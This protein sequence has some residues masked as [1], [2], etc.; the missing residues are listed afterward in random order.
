MSTEIEIFI[1]KLYRYDRKNEHCSIGFPI[2]RGLVSD[3]SCFSVWDPVKEIYLPVQVKATSRYPDGSIRFVFIRFIA[4]IPA[5]KKSTFICKIQGS[6]ENAESKEVTSYSPVKITK[7]SAGYELSTKDDVTDRE[8][9]LGLSDNSDKLLDHVT[10]G[11]IAYEGGMFEGPVLR[12]AKTRGEYLIRSGSWEIVE[13]GPL[14]VILRNKGVHVNKDSDLRYSFEAGLTFWAGKSYAEVS[15]RIINDTEDPLE[16]ESLVYRIKRDGEPGDGQVFHVSNSD[17]ADKLAEK[18]DLGRVRAITA[19]SNYKTDYYIGGDGAASRRLIDAEWLMKEANEH[20]AETFYGTFFADVTGEDTGICATIFQA[21]QN[22]PKAVEADG[23]GIALFLVPEGANSIVLQS[24]MSREQRFLIHFHEAKE[25][26][27]SLN[28]RSI[29][30]QMPYRP[31]VLPK[32]HQR[33]GVWPDVFSKKADYKVEQN[34]I[35]RADGHCRAYGM[36]NFGDCYDANY[37]AQGRGC[38]KLVWSN[39]EYDY[40]HACAIMF[41]RTGIRRF[42]DYNIAAAR[43]WM[44]VD[45]CHFHR[46]PIYV[47]GQWEHT[48]GHVIDGKMVCSHEW[49][50]GLLDYYHLTGDE[51]G[52]E[53][54]LG[55]GDNVN[56]LLDTPMYAKAGEISA[57]ETGWAL[58]TL[59]ALYIETGDKKWLKKCDKILGDFKTWEEQYGHWLSPYTDNTIIRVGFMISVAIGSLMRY[60]REFPDQ[61]QRNL[62][63]RAVDDLIENCYVE[64]W[65]IFYYK[66]LPSLNRLGNNTLLLEA[67]TIAYDLTKDQKYLEYGM[68]TFRKAVSDSPNYSGSKRKEED[69]VLVGT[70]STKNFAQSMIPIA[71]FHRAMVEAGLEL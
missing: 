57:R 33:A 50:E 69:A 21:Q 39:N 61:E 49:V 16:V 9:K 66:E 59:T 14:C 18:E 60:Y 42:L 67:M 17:E 44:D 4:D 30:Y 35:A 1:D 55:I 23:S 71:G 52:L 29:V 31:Y 70:T 20:F 54:A 48:V 36:L 25:S 45:V 47:G 8:F 6:D 62:I 51:R 12:T 37:T 10:F 28:D 64:E 34:L 5:N 43:H 27:S 15:Y 7:T 40:P 58:R 24:G 41:A 11:N 63:I 26:I 13:E 65:G 2:E 32:V 38:G 53:T 56:R 3:T 46:D 68:E 19:S 22:F